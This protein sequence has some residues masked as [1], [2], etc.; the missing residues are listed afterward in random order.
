MQLSSFSVASA[1]SSTDLSRRRKVSRRQPRNRVLLAPLLHGEAVNGGSGCHVNLFDNP[2]QI[3]LQ[4]R[5]ASAISSTE[6]SRKGGYLEGDEEKVPPSVPP[7]LGTPAL[8]S[9]PGILLRS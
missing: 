7:W 4:L 8:V 5:V 9:W 1:N 6:L 2:G 3:R